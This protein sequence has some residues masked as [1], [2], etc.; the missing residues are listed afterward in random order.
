MNEILEFIKEQSRTFPELIRKFP[1]L[2]GND[3]YLEFTIKNVE[4]SNIILWEFS[5]IG[6]EIL[7]KLWNEK[8]IGFKPMGSDIERLVYFI[9]GCVLKLPI[10]KRSPKL[11]YK[12]PHWLPV[13]ITT[14]KKF[15]EWLNN[16]S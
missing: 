4:H 7:V 6:A 3:A 11:G 1:I 16:D 9:D 14:Y 10:V 15:E 2:E 5:K 12:K 13:W 8:R